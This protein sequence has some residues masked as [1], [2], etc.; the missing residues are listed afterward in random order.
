MIFCHIQMDHNYCGLPAQETTAEYLPEKLNVRADWASTN[1]QNS[2]RWVI[3]P[4]GFQKKLSK[5]E[6][7]C[8]GPLVSRERHQVLA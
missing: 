5:M 8:T 3:S 7:F 6:C 4:R 2:S 1:F